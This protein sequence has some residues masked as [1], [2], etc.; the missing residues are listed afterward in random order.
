VRVGSDVLPFPRVLPGG[1]VNVAVA[2]QIDD[3]GGAGLAARGHEAEYRERARLDFAPDLIGSEHRRHLERAYKKVSSNA[4][5]VPS[6]NEV[7]MESENTAT[8]LITLPHKRFH[9][10]G[11]AIVRFFLFVTRLATEFD[12]LNNLVYTAILGIDEDFKHRI[13]SSEQRESVR[14]RLEEGPKIVGQLP[15]YRALMFQM[16]YTRAVDNFL[17]YVSELIALIFR[18]RPDTLKSNATV[19]LET[20]LQFKAMD[21][22]IS[23]LTER[24]VQDLSYK[25]MKTLS[26]YLS[27]RL[28]FELFIRRDSLERAVEIIEFRNLIVH[29]RALVDSVFVERMPKYADRIGKTLD[30]EDEHELPDTLEFLSASAL[31][32]DKRASQKFDLPRV[33][34]REAVVKTP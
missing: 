6:R 25:G 20:I 18:T 2:G 12:K 13:I 31:D 19:R 21:D 34:I 10:E 7:V 26:E 27:K 17:A 1:D 8:H 16:M 28:A 15:G 14:R 24:R 29:N 22:L 32:I 23:A 4:D 3:A 33:E 5:I 11:A 30:V 9:E